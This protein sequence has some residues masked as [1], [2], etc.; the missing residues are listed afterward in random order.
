M[1]KK[2][3]ATATETNDVFKFL[4]PAEID[5][6]IKLKM[7]VTKREPWT[8]AETMMRNQVIIDLLSQ[9]LS[10]RRIVEEIMSRWG[11]NQAT[12]YR[13]IRDAMAILVEGNEEFLEFNRD[14]QIERL[15]N[16]ITEAMEA[17]EYKAA[18]MATAELNKLLGL[19]I[20]QKVTIENADRTFKFGGE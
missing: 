10:R 14:K 6:L 8:E 5:A 12:A 16:I 11:I 2:L 15:E 13:W 9:G 3:T 4:D 19:T 20:N 7:N 17:H 1:A 18:V